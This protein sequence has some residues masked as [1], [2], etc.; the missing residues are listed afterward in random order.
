M[1]PRARR[2]I[3]FTL[4]ETLFALSLVALL[5]SASAW[6][7]R[8]YVERARDTAVRQELS[9]LR[10]GLAEFRAAKG[11]FPAT[12]GETEGR[13][14]RRVPLR[15]RAGRAEGDYAYDRARGDVRLA[16]RAG[17][18]ADAHGRLYEEY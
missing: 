3:G 17:E 1:I 12:L 7:Y 15:F 18:R 10:A 4:I 6:N 2:R 11:D 16:V 5:A 13:T 9:A 8:A 14:M